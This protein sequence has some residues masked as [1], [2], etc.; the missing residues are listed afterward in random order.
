[1]KKETKQKQ[2]LELKIAENKILIEDSIEKIYQK[3]IQKYKKD[4]KVYNRKDLGRWVYLGKVIHLKKKSFR[5]T[6]EK[7]KGKNNRRDRW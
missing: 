6:E 3:V 2:V 1:M 7:R 5:K 4:S